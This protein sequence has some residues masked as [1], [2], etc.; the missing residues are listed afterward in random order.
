MKDPITDSQ[1]VDELLS[2][3]VAEVVDKA[4]LRQKLLSGQRLRVK[5]GID[6]TGPTLHLGR[7][8]P[9]LKLRDFQELGHQIVLIIGSF[10]GQVGDTSDKDAERPMLTEEQVR[11]NMAGYLEQI[12]ALL[13][14]EDVEVHYNDE[15]LSKLALA[16]V[17][18]LADGFS[19]HE[20][21][22]RELIKKR[23]EA[24]KRINLR[25]V[26]YPLMQGYD[27]VAVKADVEIGGTD[28]W[29]NL[30]TG[31]TV[32]PL[33]DQVGQDVMTLQLIDGTDGQKMSTS[34]GNTFLLN[35][36]A[37][38]MYGA[39]MSIRDELIIPYFTLLTRV[40][41][42]EIGEFERQLAAGENPRD[43]KSKL[44]VAITTIYHGAG[45]AVA[46]AESFT[47]VFSQSER[48]AELPKV[49]LEAGER[50]LADILVEAQLVESKSE[51]RRLIDQGG[52]RVDDA[53][54]S[55][56]GALIG[57][58]NGLVLQIG[59]RRWAEIEIRE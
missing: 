26:L 7:S 9:L 19:L 10:T 27:S 11:T 39:I 33:Y 53:V 5:L 41:L 6:P 37:E 58:R 36:S 44:A 14:V 21:T 20:F 16:D 38:Q 3:G 48:P 24:G 42:E 31:R 51:A 18:K 8:I 45:D 59:K 55:E 30:L 46:A 40:S 49:S 47:K 17:V 50:P 12:T 2:R 4:N 22:S 25:E 15:W 29:F 32:Q 52:V 13:D 35:D 57:L 43:I 28:Q 54:V 56:P 1:K 23:L 34:K